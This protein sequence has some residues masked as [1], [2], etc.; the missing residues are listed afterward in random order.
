MVNQIIVRDV[1]FTLPNATGN[2][3]ITDTGGPGLTPKACIIVLSGA[4]GTGSETNPARCSI[5][6]TDGTNAI[7]MGWMA[8]HGVLAANADTGRRRANDK[9]LNIPGTAN[10]ALGVGAAFVSVGTNALTINVDTA[11]VLKGFVRFMYGA[12][13]TAKVTTVA[14]HGTVDNAVSSPSLGFQADGCFLISSRTQWNVDAGLANVIESFGFAGRLPSLTQACMNVCAGDRID[15]TSVGQNPRSN[16]ALSIV[17]STAGVMSEAVAIEVTNFAADT[18][19]F[20]TRELG[21]VIGIGIL[22]FSLNG[23]KCYADLATLNS[24]TSGISSYTT[25]GFRARA[26][27]LLGQAGATANT[28]DSTTGAMS[29]GVYAPPT[30]SPP[31]GGSAG[32]SF[33]K[34]NS[35]DNQSTSITTCSIAADQVVH[36]E[37]KWAA[38][39]VTTT[40][41]GFDY[42][43]LVTA[44]ADLPTV[45]FSVGE[46]P[47]TLQ[48][49]SAVAL[50]L[51]LP[52]PARLLTETPATVPLALALPQP[53]RLLT[54]TPAAAPLALVLPAPTLLASETPIAVPLTL[55]IPAPARLLTETPAALPLALDLPAPIV[56]LA[57]A[58]NP[59]P[60]ALA[61]ALPAPARLLTET[62]VA[63]PIALL[64]PAVSVVVETGAI[65]PSPVEL[66]LV[67]PALSFL[68]VDVRLDL[69]AEIARTLALEVETPRALALL[70]ETARSLDLLAATE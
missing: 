19:E 48:T 68:H 31:A 24:G 58:Q 9:I 5:G 29:I 6:L 15:P 37:S 27:F 64:V 14:S 25:P 56:L 43:V 21:E 28:L 30:G 7:A 61:L 63:V 41:T 1:P 36:V 10:E 3:T 12:N 57:N 16:R 22:A 32:G 47:D 66:A 60:V 62:P 23:E 45:V 40:P 13:L 65:T 70:E 52:A 69:V 49:P 42:N 33:A 67:L 17:I 26:L 50:P 38:R 51:V 20:T 4:T 18:I 46:L 59:A 2:F 35:A 54:E 11:S 55:A 53:A 34:W 39:I 44:S 8:E